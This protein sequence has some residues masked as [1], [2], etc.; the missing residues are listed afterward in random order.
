MTNPVSFLMKFAEQALTPSD[1]RPGD[2]RRRDITDSTLNPDIP[3]NF[4][5]TEEHHESNL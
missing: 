4:K 5:L 3:I 1:N 2:G